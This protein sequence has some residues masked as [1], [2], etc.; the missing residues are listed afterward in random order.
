MLVLNKPYKD[1]A[2]AIFQGKHEKNVCMDYK[3][4]K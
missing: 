4:S 3:T 1:C 2:I